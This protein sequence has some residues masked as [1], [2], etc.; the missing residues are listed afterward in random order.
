MKT[1]LCCLCACLIIQQSIY[2]QSQLPE[3]YLSHMYIV[4]D[5]DTYQ[6][7]FDS[8]FI[9]EK[10]GRT[11]TDSVTTADDAWFG[12]YLHGKNGYF[13]FFSPKGFKGASVGDIGFG[14]MTYTSGDIWKIKNRWAAMSADSIETDT[15]KYMSEGVSHSWYYSIAVSDTDSAPPLSLW[16]MENTPELL[17]ENGFSEEEIKNKITWQDYTEK[18]TK[19]KNDRSFDRIRSVELSI[20]K[21]EYEYL[22]KSLSGFGFREK[23][24]TF[25]TDD[26]SITYTIQSNPPMRVK[27]IETALLENFP[28][29]IITISNKLTLQLDGN[30]AI[31]KFED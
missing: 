9:K 20:N 31:W 7:L 10:L 28:P 27:T 17:K 13:E 5:E 26:I 14:F 25:F 16:I 12:K 19:K 4:L 6:K 30:K 29:R 1:L 8:A 23:E 18:K 11:R 21:S 15:T 2:A 22:K 24:N 3:I